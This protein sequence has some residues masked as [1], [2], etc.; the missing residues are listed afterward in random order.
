M[1]LNWTLEDINEMDL[2][3][4]VEALGWIFEHSPWVAERA[5][6]HGPFTSIDALHSAM[7]EAVRSATPE[8]RLKLLRAHPDLAGRLQMSSASV[9]E[10]KNAGLSDLTPEEYADFTACNNT[11]TGKFGFPF[12]MAVRGQNKHS[13]REA[14]LRRLDS[15]PEAEL[16]TAL[17]E[18]AKIARFRLLDLLAP[19]GE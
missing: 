5:F 1:Y 14:M 3:Q 9:S 12:I 19:T 15:T 6:P 11:Y 17:Q 18:V 2:P 8:E 13:I 10:Q 16:D 7:A 4:F